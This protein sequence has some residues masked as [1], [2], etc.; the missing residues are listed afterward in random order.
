MAKPQ[1]G[2][3]HA[4]YPAQIDAAGVGNGR[5]RAGEQESAGEQLGDGE[6][7]LVEFRIPQETSR[8]G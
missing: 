1:D 8:D 3:A 7:F 2:H 6:L 5:E 4:S